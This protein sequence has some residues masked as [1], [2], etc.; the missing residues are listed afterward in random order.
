MASI[1]YGLISDGMT[2]RFFLDVSAGFNYNSTV[3]A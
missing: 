3:I 1:D 2:S